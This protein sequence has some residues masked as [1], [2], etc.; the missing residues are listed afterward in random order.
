MLKR[1]QYTYHVAFSSIAKFQKAIASKPE[2]MMVLPPVII[3]AKRL[4]TI[5]PTWNNGIIFTVKNILE[6]KLEYE[7][8]VTHC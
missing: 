2:H 3:G 5:P 7:S 1:K 8:N 6:S 4:R